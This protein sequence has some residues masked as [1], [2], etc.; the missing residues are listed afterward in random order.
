MDDLTEAWE[1][2][3]IRTG[4]IRLG[5]TPARM[6]AS[7]RLVGEAV[8]EIRLLRCQQGEQ[9]GEPHAHVWAWMSTLN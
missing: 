7:R 6:L 2:P 8:I 1:D 4:L 3:V 9:S 5:L